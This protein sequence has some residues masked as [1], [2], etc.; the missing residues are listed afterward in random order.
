MS[1][2]WLVVK[3]SGGSGLG[4][5]IKSVL[6][7]ALYASLSKR[8]FVVDWAGSVY[9]DDGI[10]IFPKIFKIKGLESQLELQIR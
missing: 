7:G 6:V 10:N 4:D 2:K 8:I 9:S 1:D 5:L 3:A